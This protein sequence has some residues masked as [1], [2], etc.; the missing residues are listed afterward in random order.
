MELTLAV[1]MNNRELALLLWIGIFMAWV[2]IHPKTR[3][4]LPVLLKAAFQPKLIIIYGV[5]PLIP[6]L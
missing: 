4:T 6:L 5:M 1:E 3:K 2:V